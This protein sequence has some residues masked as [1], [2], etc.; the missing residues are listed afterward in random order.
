MK[1][2][3][4][5]ILGGMGPRATLAF[6]QRLLDAFEGSD[7]DLPRIISVNDGQIPDRTAFLTMK[8]SDPYIALMR[9]AKILA[10]AGVDVVCLPCNTAHAPQILGR[11]QAQ[12]A[13]PFIDMPA[14]TL[15]VAE[16]MELKK[17]LILS[18]R[19]TIVSRVYQSRSIDI[20]CVFPTNL[21]QN[22]IDNAI[23]CIK[24][25]NIDNVNIETLRKIIKKSD[26]DGVVLA[27]TELS[28]LG[29][30]L[31]VPGVKQIDAV[32]CLVQRCVE[33]F[34]SYNKIEG[35]SV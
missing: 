24:L 26:C 19:G 15:A 25:G 13:L 12:L 9:S 27:C 29:N 32:D 10:S 8:G 7:Q 1:I 31:E 2:P 21:S 18:T 6:E 30:T 5:G 22:Q 14:A 20:I 16:A 33:H 35:V 28:M 17:L 23:E 11:L 34:S 3:T 4:I